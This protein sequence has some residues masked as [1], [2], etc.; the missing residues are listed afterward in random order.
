MAIADGAQIWRRDT[1]LDEPLV[2]STNL[3][4]WL[5]TARRGPFAPGYLVGTQCP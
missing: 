3:S 4:Y 5:G 2:S 1:V